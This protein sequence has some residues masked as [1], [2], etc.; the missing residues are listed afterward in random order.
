MDM[1]LETTEK[2]LVES[3]WRSQPED[4]SPITKEKLLAGIEDT[5]QAMDAN[6]KR[7]VERKGSTPVQVKQRT[8]GRRSMSSSGAL[9]MIKLASLLGCHVGA[10]TA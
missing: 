5:V 9:L 7:R 2:E 3:G 10:F 6:L 4:E 1:C 8:R